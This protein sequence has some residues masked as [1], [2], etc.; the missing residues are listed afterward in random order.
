MDTKIAP[1]PRGTRA[2]EKSFLETLREDPR[3]R[4]DAK[5]IGLIAMTALILD[6][7]M[8]GLALSGLDYDANTHQVIV[9]ASFVTTLIVV[10]AVVCLV[11]RVVDE[12]FSFYVD[13]IE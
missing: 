3:F 4:L 11:M 7:V 9:F 5:R 1:K 2:A 10:S 13:R 12:F 6:A 8:F